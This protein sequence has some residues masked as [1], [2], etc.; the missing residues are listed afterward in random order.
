MTF[1]FVQEGP[2]CG[3]EDITKERNVNRF[4]FFLLFCLFDGHHGWKNHKQIK[5][6]ALK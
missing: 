4:D 1:N 5:I 2:S 6:T 3:S